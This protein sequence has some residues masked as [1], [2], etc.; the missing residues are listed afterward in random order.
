MKRKTFKGLTILSSGLGIVL[1]GGLSFVGI[2]SQGFKNWDVQN[3]FPKKQAPL[4]V[5]LKNSDFVY[6][7]YSIGCDDERIDHSTWELRDDLINEQE[8][9]FIDYPN[10]GDEDY[11]SGNPIYG[12]KEGSEILLPISID[13]K[14]EFEFYV[15]CKRSTIGESDFILAFD[16]EIDGEI[17]RDG[18]STYKDYA[19]D[20]GG[21]I[22][23]FEAGRHEIN[24]IVK[25][26]NLY[27]SGFFIHFVNLED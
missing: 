20:F 13:K 12:L 25:D 9:F 19:S 17:A 23:T 3:W 15:A 18:I 2:K 4:L 8:G 1:L 7:T 16:V 22:G 21:L 10:P 5:D 26:E 24:L 27:I 11:M 6:A 14:M